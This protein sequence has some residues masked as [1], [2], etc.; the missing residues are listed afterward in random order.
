MRRVIEF[1]RLRGIR[2]VAEF[3][4]P[5]A[6]T[7][8]YFYYLAHTG[9][10]GLGQPGLLSECYDQNGNYH[11][12]DIIDPT[13]SE[14]FEFLAGFFQVDFELLKCIYSICA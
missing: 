13:L 9:S 1:A 2:V 5:G 3:D 11:L 6:I 7:F 4:T 10:W 8:R 14:N 12:P